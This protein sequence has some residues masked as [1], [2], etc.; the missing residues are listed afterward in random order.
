MLFRGPLKGVTKGKNEAPLRLLKRNCAEK[1]AELVLTPQIVKFYITSRCERQIGET[2][3]KW[4]Y[5]LGIAA[6]PASRHVTPD[7]VQDRVLFL[8]YVLFSGHEL[9]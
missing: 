1:P 3:V 7:S 2:E 8:Q 9:Q 5:L 6:A 4:Q